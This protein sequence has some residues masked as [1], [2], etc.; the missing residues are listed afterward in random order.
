MPADF[1]PADEAFLT[2]TTWGMRPVAS[3]DGAAV[4]E[5]GE[6]GP[7]TGELARRFDELGEERHH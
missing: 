2:H 4:G 5:R 3:V 7:V 6:P 1:R